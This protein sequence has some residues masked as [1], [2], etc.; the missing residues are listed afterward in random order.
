MLRTEGSSKFSGP[1]RSSART[2][3]A[4]TV[5]A[6]ALLGSHVSPA[7][8]AERATESRAAAIK[9]YETPVKSERGAILRIGRKLRNRQPLAFA[10]TN[11]E[12]T[13]RDTTSPSGI[14]TCDYRLPVVMK[15]LGEKLFFALKQ[16]KPEIGGL[17][18]IRASVI[19]EVDELSDGSPRM[20]PKI[21]GA[22]PDGTPG[23]RVKRHGVTNFEYVGTDNDCT[24]PPS[25]QPQA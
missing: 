10:D 7:S 4:G 21:V 25:P 9:P 1:E 23:I 8:S 22:D 6:G 17:A 19:G 15:V 12:A 14:K 18:T 2:L 13:T 16:T 5:A 20:I 3:L 24:V 11:I